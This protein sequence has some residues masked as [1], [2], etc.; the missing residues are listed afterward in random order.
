YDFDIWYPDGFKVC[1]EAAAKFEAT[2]PRAKSIRHSLRASRAQLPDDEPSVIFVKVPE[3]WISDIELAEQ[4]TAVA[5]DYLRQSDHVVS[6]KYYPPITIYT[7][8]ATARWHAYCEVSNPKFLNRNWDMFRDE[9]VPMNGFPPWWIRFY[10]ELR[11]PECLGAASPAPN[12]TLL[13][14]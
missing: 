1:A 4:I 3:G 9:T 8:E 5:L 11:M 12:E 14:P 13:P 7:T 6:V 10:P 2:L